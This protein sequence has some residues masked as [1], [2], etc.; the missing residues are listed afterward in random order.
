MSVE[1]HYQDSEI[2]PDV[3]TCAAWNKTRFDNGQI[4]ITFVDDVGEPLMMVESGTV[5][6]ILINN[7]MSVDQA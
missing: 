1:V 5:R 3:I 2:Q 6:M 4:F 7:G